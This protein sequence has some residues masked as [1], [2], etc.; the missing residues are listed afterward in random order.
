MS[1]TLQLGGTNLAVHS[2]SG[3]SAK[4]TLDSG[5]EFPAG[6]I[7]GHSTPFVKTGSTSIE[8]TST[9]FAESGV[10]V[11]ITPKLSSADSRIVI[12][13]FTGYPRTI[14]SSS[15]LLQ[16]ACSR[17]TATSTAYASA[18]QIN[19][20]NYF[21]PN[22]TGTYWSQHATFIDSGSYSAGTQYF[23]QIYFLSSGGQNV[24]LVRSNGTVT[25]LAYEVKI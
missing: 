16:Y 5:L 10:E 18:T 21:Y 2:G 24:Q 20:T 1:G 23:Y 13:F 9:T 12:Q 6:H 4:I 8:T 19:Q 14:G 25:M 7:I 22:S 3:A 17:A 15:T 11:N